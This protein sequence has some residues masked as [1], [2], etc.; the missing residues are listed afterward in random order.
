[1]PLRKDLP[2]L[3]FLFHDDIPRAAYVEAAIEVAAGLLAR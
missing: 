1:V 2:A 3:A